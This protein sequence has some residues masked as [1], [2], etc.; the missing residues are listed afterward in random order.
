[1]GD[2]VD[3]VL[4]R[5]FVYWMVLFIVPFM[6]IT[7]ALAYYSVKPEWSFLVG[8]VFAFAMGRLCDKLSDGY[9]ERVNG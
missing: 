9:A 6:A 3:A 5:E 2:I 8:I 1:M 4:S 7:N